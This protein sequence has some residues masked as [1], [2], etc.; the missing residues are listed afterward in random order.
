MKGQ[1]DT[2]G[3]AARAENT[4][5]DSGPKG[6]EPRIAP[7][8]SKDHG[9]AFPRPRLLDRSGLRFFP[10]R[11]HQGIPARLP[12]YTRVLWPVVRVLQPTLP[13]P[14]PD[15]PPPSG[16]KCYLPLAAQRPWGGGIRLK[17]S[18]LS[19]LS[20]TGT[21]HMASTPSPSPAPED[22][23]SARNVHSRMTSR[24]SVSPLGST[25]PPLPWRGRRGGGGVA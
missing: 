6:Q 15:P 20:R 22:S 14:K 13:T 2:T 9:G 4:E 23:A 16:Q 19:V 24:A 1:D 17:G 3:Q 11:C 7:R 21:P 5:Q 10:S 18:L 25:A 12:F 8:R